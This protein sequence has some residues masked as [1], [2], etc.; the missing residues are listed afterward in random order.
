[1]LC[2][3]LDYWVTFCE[4]WMPVYDCNGTIFLWEPNN[5]VVLFN[6][7]T[8]SGKIIEWVYILS[9]ESDQPNV[10]KADSIEEILPKKH[11]L[12]FF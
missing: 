8:F 2:A 5:S 4:N 6:I 3:S 1:M 9:S 7:S 12:R 10:G 11:F